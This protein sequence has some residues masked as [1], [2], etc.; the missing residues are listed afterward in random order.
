[1]ER[2]ARYVICIVAVM[3][4]KGGMSGLLAGNFSTPYWYGVGERMA[5]GKS[6]MGSRNAFGKS[7]SDE[8]GLPMAGLKAGSA[9]VKSAY[10]N[11]DAD[12]VLLLERY[13]AGSVERE[14]IPSAKAMLAD[15]Y[16]KSGRT[17]DAETL[18]AGIDSRTLSRNERELMTLNQAIIKYE[19]GDFAGTERLLDG[20]PPSPSSQYGDD[21]LFYKSAACYATGGYAEAE[22]GFDKL[23][24]T[25]KYS[26]AARYFLTGIYYADKRFG[27]A[28]ESGEELLAASSGDVSARAELLRIC[29]ESAFYT[30]EREKCIRFLEEYAGIADKPLPTDFYMLGVSYYSDGNYRGAI[31][32]LGRVEGDDEEL[33]QS[34]SL[35]LGHSYLAE[36]DK[37]G[38]LLAYGNAVERGS[39][40]PVR[41]AALFNYALLLNETSIVSFEKAVATFES[42]VNMFPDSRNVDVI[43]RLLVNRYFTADNY[44]EALASIENIDNPDEVILKARQ[45][46]LY[47]MGSQ[48]YV[49]GDMD[50]AFSRFSQ[51]ADMGALSPDILGKALLWRGEIAYAKGDFAAA[52][53]DFSKALECSPSVVPSVYYSLGYTRF[54]TGDYIGAEQMFSRFVSARGAT[55]RVA[56][57]AW[58]R[59]GD[60][61]YMA[62]DY[63]GASAAYV[64]GGELYPENADYAIFRQGVIAQIQKRPEGV[65]TFMERLRK[66]FPSSGYLPDAM[67]LEGMSLIASGKEN[68]GIGVLSS[69]VSRYP[70][71]DAARAASLQRAVAYVNAGDMDEALDAYKKVV[72]M[73]PGSEEAGI[74]EADLK[75]LYVQSGNMEGYMEYLND[76]RKGEGYD[77]A[78]I[79]S[80]TFLA[81]ENLFLKLPSDGIAR[82]EGYLESFPEGAFAADAAYYAG[83]YMYEKGDTSRCRQ[84]LQKAVGKGGNTRFAAE[85][86]SLLASVEENAGNFAVA[87]KLYRRISDGFPDWAGCTGARCGLVRSSFGAGRFD[88]AVSEASLLL[89][90]SLPP[91]DYA[92]MLYLRASAYSKLG[93]TEAADADMARLAADMR[94]VYGAEAA[95]RLGERRYA[96]GDMDGAAAYASALVS[97][98]TGQRY[99]VARGIVLLSDISYRKGDRYKAV[100]YLKSLSENYGEDDD[101]KEIVD[102]RLELYTD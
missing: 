72:A 13:I 87:E 55:P 66:E 100:Q 45:E 73:Y 7:L 89:N 10:E 58:C 93:E 35:Y 99:W 83:S 101:I 63:S 68:K 86:L 19:R 16:M 30:G 32:S 51:A 52:A 18:Y 17:D 29:G 78:E 81:A 48:A 38:A 77:A 76:Y 21:A 60:C 50:E 3:C 70:S 65:L 61:R 1:M 41:E 40:M 22:T 88:V 82:L 44:E 5:A 67:Y 20:F 26:D 14:G 102:K 34:A 85:S 36:G 54:S 84:F 53:T 25:E 59:I 74:A 49:D 69:L 43:N 75:N 94:S 15:L 92:H 4:V 12:A 27:R 24:R 57:D 37:D 80:L 46:I 8:S 91:N 96:A 2:L 56:A 71:S 23:S 33:M 62:S 95:Y 64:K 47:R 6:F 97:S 31:S 90:S 9:L 39:D 28:L 11:G 42:Y 79:D 98:G